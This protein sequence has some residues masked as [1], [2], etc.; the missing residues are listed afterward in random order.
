M[1]KIV[2][3]DK[4][5]TK[6]LRKSL[7]IKAAAQL[8]SVADYYHN[9]YDFFLLDLEEVGKQIYEEVI[10]YHHL[11]SSK[12]TPSTLKNYIDSELSR[13]MP[14]YERIVNGSNFGVMINEYKKFDEDKQHF[15]AE[16]KKLIYKISSSLYRQYK[17]SITIDRRS[18]WTLI[19]AIAGVI[20][21]L[22][23]LISSGTSAIGN[24][25]ENDSQNNLIGYSPYYFNL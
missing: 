15:Q 19:A 9:L 22:I 3:A 11:D 5:Y 17:E 13:M 1:E 2:N 7:K 25:G 12:L 23:G 21:T 6:T 20:L 10:D 4:H 14:N 24:T 18:F 16:A 8:G